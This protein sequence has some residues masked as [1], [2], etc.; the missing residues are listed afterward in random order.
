MT[1]CEKIIDYCRTHGSIT[2]REAFIDLHINSPTKRISEIRSSGLY[3][4]EEVQ[5]RHDD[6]VGCHYTRYYITPAEA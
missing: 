6:A 2:I 5:I 4:V 3:R 1:Q